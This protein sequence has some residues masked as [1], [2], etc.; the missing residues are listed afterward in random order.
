[1]QR[2]FGGAVTHLGSRPAHGMMQAAALIL[3]TILAW[4]PARAL[5]S[6]LPEATD[7]SEDAHYMRDAIQ[8]MVVLFSQ[9]ACSWCDRVRAQL[10]PMAQSAV[11]QGA[12][13]FRQIDIDRDAPMV[14]FS[15]KATSHRRFSRD[16][17]VRFTPTLI[18]FGPDGR[19]LAEPILG[20][21]LPDFYSQ[22]VDQ[23]IEQA[24]SVMT[25]PEVAAA[26]PD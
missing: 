10:A 3:A 11:T 21:R 25:A 18:V 4:A 17:G 26:L 8:P 2:I 19:R 16:E 13:V 12:A 15:G 20:M 1:M 6:A 23:A 5:A 9:R 22:Y 24:R 7:L 14:D